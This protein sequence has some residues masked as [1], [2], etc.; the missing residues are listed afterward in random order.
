[1]QESQT[2]SCLWEFTLWLE[3]DVCFPECQGMGLTWR[4]FLTCY[5]G[6][7]TGR[8]FSYLKSLDVPQFIECHLVWLFQT[9]ELGYL[10]TYAIAWT[11]HLPC[12]EKLD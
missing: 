1:M 6:S 7:V 9:N 10:Q 8:I 4:N 12:W 5:G 2:D 11:M 3:Q